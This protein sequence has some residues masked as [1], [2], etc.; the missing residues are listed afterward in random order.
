MPMAEGQGG[1]HSLVRCARPAGARVDTRW[2]EG[3]GVLVRG[4]RLAGAKGD[5]RWCEGEACGCEGRRSLVRGRGLRVRRG[6]ARWCEGWGLLV[7]RATLVGAKGDARWC[8]GRGLRVRGST[9][10][11]AR[12]EACWC[13]G[14]H[15]LVLVD[16]C[17]LFRREWYTVT[18]RHATVRLRMAGGNRG[19]CFGTAALAGGG[20]EGRGSR[21]CS[22]APYGFALAHSRAKQ[23]RTLPP[24]Q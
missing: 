12:V 4:A 7:R 13:E 14:R 23:I 24:V 22:G 9:L 20:S 10:V 16:G 19:K 21:R 3:R 1:R 6:D 18:P 17:G 15:S 8:E 2:C 5:A 11:G